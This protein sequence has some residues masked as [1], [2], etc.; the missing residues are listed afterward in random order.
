MSEQKHDDRDA[1]IDYA[2]CVQRG[3]DVYVVSPACAN[4]IT[5]LEC[6]LD[7][8]DD[9]SSH[10]YPFYIDSEDYWDESLQELIDSGVAKIERFHSCMKISY[11]WRHLT[12]VFG[13]I[14]ENHY[15]T[16]RMQQ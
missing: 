15:H 11:N 14:L 16:R 1:M 6:T 7:I 13:L 10:S 8:P 5:A 4:P 9:W 2:Q 3:I 12:T